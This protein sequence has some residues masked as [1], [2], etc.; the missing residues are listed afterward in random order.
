MSY[1]KKLNNNLLNLGQIHDIIISDSLSALHKFQ[2]LTQ[3][4][5]LVFLHPKSDIK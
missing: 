1:T 4:S 5:E 2:S 3:N